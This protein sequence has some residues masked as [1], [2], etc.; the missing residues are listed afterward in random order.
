M[1]CGLPDLSTAHTY[2]GTLFQLSLAECVT[3][4]DRPVQALKSLPDFLRPR[5][6]LPRGRMGA[7][8]APEVYDHR[9]DVGHLPVGQSHDVPVTLRLQQRVEQ[10]DVLLRKHLGRRGLGA[11]PREDGQVG[12][13]GASFRA[14]G[15]T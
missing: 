8:Q 13:K 3:D 14:F 4:L 11:L 15:L 2:I 9:P 1:T 12:V 10:V 5:E 6:R 7:D